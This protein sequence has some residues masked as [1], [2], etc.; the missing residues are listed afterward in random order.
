MLPSALRSSTR[1]ENQ[2][3][4]FSDMM[5]DIDKLDAQIRELTSDNIRL[6]NSLQE[7]CDELRD[8]IDGATESQGR[9][10]WITSLILICERALHPTTYGEELRKSAA[11]NGD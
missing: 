10:T 9:D 6:V 5:E 2:M 3:A 7:V 1:T 11:G 4:L 8:R